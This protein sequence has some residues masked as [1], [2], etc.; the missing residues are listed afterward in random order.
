MSLQLSPKASLLNSPADV[1]MRLKVQPTFEDW[2]PTP[3]SMAALPAAPP[4]GIV[5]EKVTKT[6]ASLA[7]GQDVEFEITQ[8][9]KGLQAAN[10]RRHEGEQ[11]A[12]EAN[13]S[14]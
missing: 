3:I 11:Q 8:G 12:A 1:L 13:Q 5:R 6:F 14:S 7:E 9:P 10:V 2:G 4:E